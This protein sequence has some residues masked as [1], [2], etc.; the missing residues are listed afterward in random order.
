MIKNKTKKVFNGRKNGNGRDNGNGEGIRITPEQVEELFLNHHR[1]LINLAYEFCY[2]RDLAED[3]VSEVY[4]KLLSGDSKYIGGS[5]ASYAR[6]SIRNKYL[7]VKK[8]LHYKA[9]S[10]DFFDRPNFEGLATPKMNS[11]DEII[12]R[13]EESK[14]Y[15]ILDEAIISMTPIERNAYHL[16]ILEELTTKETSERTGRTIGSIKMDTHRAYETIRRVF[17]KYGFVLKGRFP[18]AYNVRNER[19]R[20]SMESINQ[21]RSNPKP[22][23]QA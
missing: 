4:I 7:D 2:D 3:I 15:K 6:V 17:A 13:E 21:Q 19:R 14:M 23:R 9:H 8:G 18:I 20:K 5:L 12:H 22:N 11:E 1:S 16:R 10:I